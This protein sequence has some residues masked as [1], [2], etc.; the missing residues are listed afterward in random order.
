MEAPVRKLLVGTAVIPV[1]TLDRV[2][3]AVP[4]ARALAAGGLRVLEVTL[5]TAAA[6][7]GIQRIVA[8]VQGVIVGTGTVCTPEQVQLS[9]DLGCQFMISP[10]STERLL[11]E[12]VQAPIPLMPGVASVSEMMRCMELGY[13]DFKF[14]PAEAS[15]GAALIKAIAGPFADARFCPTG[16]IGLAN[17]LDY[18]RL[19]NVLCVGGS[20]VLPANLIAEQRWADIERLARETVEF[21]TSR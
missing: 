21:C 11:A 3:D 7:A 8:E 19:P 4:I 17:A 18:L 10:G 14:F 15:G 12:A 5:R 13:E 6:R 1:I 9:C 20:W 2:E 16:G